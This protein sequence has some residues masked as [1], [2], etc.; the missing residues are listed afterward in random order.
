MGKVHHAAS[1]HFQIYLGL[2]EYDVRVCQAGVKRTRLSSKSCAAP[3]DLWG[4]TDV[5][6]FKV[7]VGP[8]R[9]RNILGEWKSQPRRPYR[10][11]ICTLNVKT[12]PNH[13]QID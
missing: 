3:A 10:L 11:F 6:L 8:Y 13:K 12:W 5:I 9:R 7:I 2:D 1:G 4:A